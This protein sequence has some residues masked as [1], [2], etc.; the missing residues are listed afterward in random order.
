MDVVSV[1]AEGVEAAVAEEGIASCSDSSVVTCPAEVTE[2]A[3]VTLTYADA[4]GLNYRR[5]HKL[6]QEATL[7][8][9]TLEA[10]LEGYS[11]TDCDVASTDVVVESREN[12]TEGENYDID[13][14][15]EEE[16]VKGSSAVTIS[17]SSIFFVIT[18]TQL[19]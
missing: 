11:V 19:W 2:C 4:D 10:S 8:C 3:S 1:D 15:I 5:T 17:L 16:A 9:D 13:N 12:E 7:T 6:C 14:D 18:F